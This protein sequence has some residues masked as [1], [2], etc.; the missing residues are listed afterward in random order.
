MFSRQ[1]F[2]LYHVNFQTHQKI[3]RTLFI[4]TLFRGLPYNI[5]GSNIYRPIYGNQF[6]WMLHYLG[7]A[8]PLQQYLGDTVIIPSNHEGVV[9]E[10]RT[11]QNWIQKW[12]VWQMSLGNDV[13]MAV[14]I[15]PQKCDAGQQ[16]MRVFQPKSQRWC[17]QPWSNPFLT[18]LVRPSHPKTMSRIG[19]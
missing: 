15:L 12:N 8:R 4:Y 14:Y 16:K 5:F 6:R 11:M 10:A 9:D 19:H 18:K 13:P 3:E 1:C 2:L 17:T 7:V